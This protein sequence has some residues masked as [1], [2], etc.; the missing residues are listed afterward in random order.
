MKT[1]S[2]AFFAFAALILLEAVTYATTPFVEFGPVRQRCSACHRLDPQGRLEVIEETRKSPEEWIHVVDRMIRLNGAPI[3]DKDF[4]PVVKELS[5]HLILMPTEMAEVAYYNSE[6]N[7]Q[8][9]EIPKD[10][11]EMRIFTA[12]VRCH[13]YAK[14]RSHRNTRAQWVENVN[15]HL[16]YYPTVVPQMREMN[17][18]KEAMELV[19][20][21]DKMLPMDTQAWRDWMKS[22]QDQ[23]LAG[24]WNLAGYQPGLGYYEGSYAFKPNQKGE[25]EYLI[26]KEVRYENGITM[27]WVGE[28]TLYGAY[29]LRYELAP[30]PLTG[31]I[32]GVFDLDAAVSGFSG[33]W[34]TVVQDSNTYGNEAFYKEGGS[35]RIIAVYPKAIRASGEPQILTAV[36]VNLPSK[37]SAVDVKFSDANVK[38]SNAAKE[39][40]GKIILEVVAGKGAATGPASIQVDGLVC[41]EPIMVFNKIDGIRIYP[42]LGRA[43]VSCGAAYPPHGVQF[44]A[45][46]V[47]F[48]KDGEPETE[49][50]LI[51]EPVEAKWWLEEE[52]TRENDDD[53]KYLNTS[54][55]NGLYTPVTTYAPIESRFQRREGVGLIAVGASFMEN[56]SELKGRSLLAVTEPDFVTHIK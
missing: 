32:E 6:E 12:C 11:T 7:S 43:R 39:G 5:K 54:V 27:K 34:W 51:L 22:R 21:L 3:D 47:H 24:K 41:E 4:Y 48:G 35:P 44:V 1:C 56:G 19:D 42:A 37:V 31:R 15:M 14:I 46:A 8:Y 2:V 30:A 52:V 36:G 20:V 38:V 17:W 18:P 16:G 40:E 13:T 49:D 45:R 50:D 28:G 53:L 33:K 10:E 26:E 29:H 9:R 25:D 55:M 23:D